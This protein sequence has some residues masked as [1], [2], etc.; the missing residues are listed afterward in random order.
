LNCVV[1][2]PEVLLEN[3]RFY[4]YFVIGKSEILFLRCNWN[5]VI[6]K[7]EILFLLRN[8]NCVIGKSEILFL[9]RNGNCVIGK[10][11]ILFLLHNWKI[12]DFIPTA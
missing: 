11:E 1:G 2:K 4:S 8:R 5:C 12:G 10:S 3:Q 6:G 7:P 9:L